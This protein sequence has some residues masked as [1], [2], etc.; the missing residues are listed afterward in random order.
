MFIYSNSGEPTRLTGWI[1]DFIPFTYHGDHAM[2]N[3]GSRGIT[4]RQADNPAVTFTDFL[5]N[6]NG[7]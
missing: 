5:L 2:K 7:T 6:D 4:V 3:E 1:I